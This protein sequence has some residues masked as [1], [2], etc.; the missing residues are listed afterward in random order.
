MCLKIWA[1]TLVTLILFGCSSNEQD[2][3]RFQLLSSNETHIKFINAIDETDS[4]NILTY[5]YMYNGGGVG[6]ID[7][8]NDGLSD[9]FFTGNQTPNALYLNKGNFQFEDISTSA[10]IELKNEWC[11][12]VSVVDI[13]SDGWEDIYVCVGGVGNKNIFPDRLFINQGDLTFKEMAGEYGLADSAESIQSVFFDYDKDGDLDMY[14]LV[15]GG[16]EMSAIAVRPIMGRGENR[17]TD[18]LY[19]N[20]YDSTLGHPVF[21][22]VSAQ[23]GILLEGFGLGVSII[24]ANL[25]TWPDVFVSNDYLSRDVLYIN[26]HD[27][28]FTDKGLS[29]F[30]HTSHFSMGNDVGDLNNDGLPDIVTVDMLPEDHGRRK[31]MFGPNDYERFQLAVQQDYGYQYMRNMLQVNHGKNGFSEVGQLAGIQRTDWSWAPLIADFDNDGYQDIFIT[32]G[33]GRDVT[34]L[35]FVKFREAGSPFSDRKEREK[36]F[37]DSLKK[38]PSVVL[39]DYIYRNEKNLTFSD[40]SSNWGITQPSISNG[41]A[42]ADLDNDGD[43]DIVVNNLNQE[44]FIYQNTTIE[45]DSVSSNFLRVKLKGPSV[46]ATGFGAVVKVYNNGKEQC[47]YQQVV[48]GFQSSVEKVIHIGLGA[49]NRIDSLVV[50]WPDGKENRFTDLSVNIQQEVEYRKAVTTNFMKEEPSQ[51]YFA[52]GMTIDF[53]HKETQ[54]NDFRTQPLLINGRSNQGP[55]IAV[56]DVNGDGLEDMFV[57]GAYQSSG[58]VFI[59]KKKMQ[60]EKR[61]LPDNEFEDLGSILFDA[62][63]DADLDLYVVSGGSERYEEHTGYQ[64]RLYTNDG[65]GNFSLA[66][67]ALPIMLSSTAAVAA[68]DFDLDGDLDLF[69]GGRVR[70]GK[71]P[72]AP[73]SYMLENQGGKFVDITEKI[74]PSLRNIG[75][76]TAALWTDFNNDNRPDLVLAGEFMRLTLF[77]NVGNKLTDITDRTSLKESYGLWNS[78]ASADFDNDGDL[79]FVAGNIGLNTSFQITPDHPMEIHYGDFDNNGSLDPIISVYEG[80][81]SYPL[82]S[83]DQLTRQLPALKRN[84]LYYRQYARTT[85]DQLLQLLNANQPKTLRCNIASTSFIENS[86]NGNF[87]ITHLPQSVQVAPVNGIAVEDLNADGMQDLILVGNSYDQQ[88]ETGRYDASTGAVLLNNGQSTFQPLDQAG[89]FFV[90]GDARGIVRLELSDNQSLLMVAQNNDSLLSFRIDAYNKQ[91]R[92]FLKKDECKAILTLSD[93]HKRVMEFPIGGAY[94]SQSSKSIVISPLIRQVETFNAKGQSVRIITYGKG[95]S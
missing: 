8:N 92:V 68:G 70:P 66:K 35:D 67:D 9:L 74:N 47:R 41:A 11:T 14:L 73:D 31:Q 51:N 55:G 13:N 45:H 20:T 57:G 60:F 53:V 56:G 34:D 93:G 6:V 10:G 88:I 77:E 24:D 65:K 18:K 49:H 23:A 22:D 79:D 95:A 72:E 36:L 17:N 71:Y 89:N 75:M 58:A 81:T 19:R 27:G 28:T 3:K 87:V 85:T 32:N 48:R 5:E 76:V 44:P 4:I 42:Y 46:N 2:S 82:A 50:A 80:D 30:K 63:G 91:E 61:S 62:D 86:G 64:D 94:L 84:I 25:D 59:Q 12:G 29:Y 40:Q 90:N 52:S 83:L 21:E 15:G 39:P 7:V 38:R 78:I 1:A 69:V 37:L 16:F 26:N 33:F 43:L 54:S